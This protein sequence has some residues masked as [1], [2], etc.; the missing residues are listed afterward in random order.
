[1]ATAGPPTVEVY[2]ATDVR[3]DVNGILQLECR[4]S[5]RPEPT[6]TW[7]RAVSPVLICVM[8]TALLL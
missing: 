5:G 7:T 8:S 4:A 2:P 6:V 3:V 1:L